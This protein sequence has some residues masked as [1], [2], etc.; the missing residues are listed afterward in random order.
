MNNVIRSSKIEL[1]KEKKQPITLIYQF[2]IHDNKLRQKGI[3]DCLKENVKNPFISKIILLNERIYTAAELGIDSDKIEQ[4]NIGNRLYFSDVLDYVDNNKIKGYILTCNADIFFDKT[5][6]KIYKS[7]L[8]NTKSV[9]SQLRF[10]YSNKKLQKCKVFGPRSDYQDSWMFHSNYNVPKRYREAFKIHYGIA[11]CNI[12]LNYIFDILGYKVLCDPF[13]IKTYHNHD[14]SLAREYATKPPIET[15]HCLVIPHMSFPTSDE[16]FPLNIHAK[17]AGLSWKEYT[18]NE[19]YF[20][21]SA[22]N[23]HMENYLEKCLSS[24]TNFIIPKCNGK[25]NFLSHLMIELS[26]QPEGTHTYDLIRFELSGK[27]GEL[28]ESDLE[29]KTARDLQFVCTNYL[30]TVSVEPIILQCSPADHLFDNIDKMTNLA[31]GHRL[32]FNK[33]KQHRNTPVH[34]NVLNIGEYTNSESC[35]IS[36]ITNKKILL[37]SPNYKLLRTQTN[38]LEQGNASFYNMPM[39]QNCSF[40]CIDIP[41]IDTEKPLIQNINEYIQENN[42]SLLSNDIILVGD[43]VIEFLLIKF[44]KQINKSAISVG[45]LLDLWFGLYSEQQ[46]KKNKEVILINKNKHWKYIE[47]DSGKT[48]E[49]QTVI[50]LDSTEDKSEPASEPTTKSTM[51]QTSDSASEPISNNIQMTIIQDD[52]VSQS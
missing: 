6:K 9:I 22:N 20:I 46:N 51:E 32:I 43:T 26:K 38:K 17:R 13:Y 27:I 8:H 16:V 44:A 15:P 33:S 21:K 50:N 4:V 10:E 37:I 7:G 47:P 12:K 2:F 31:K 14:L 48:I 36:K 52:T 24:N 41:H 35:W 18:N 49:E 39:F 1:H 23:K 11:C 19:K 45:S 5:L 29:I 42:N 30:N 3:L 25:L 28:N 40:E 34:T